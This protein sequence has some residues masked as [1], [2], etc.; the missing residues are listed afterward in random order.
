MRTDVASSARTA[1]HRAGRG[2]WGLIAEWACRVG[3]AARGFVY[4]SIG[5][6]ALMAALDRTPKAR[7]ALGALEAWA[8]WPFGIAL[9]W[10]T[11]LGLACFAGWRLLQSVFDA[12]R[13]GR[14]PKAIAARIGQAISGAVYGGLA[15]SLME[16]LDAFED[17]R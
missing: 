12:D 6:V 2:P 14:E 5:F 11:A 1:L 4:V 15:L 13:Q 8:D 7:G 3:Y 10:L 17:L 16:L 9:L